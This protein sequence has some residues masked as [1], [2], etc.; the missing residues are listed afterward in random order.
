MVEVYNDPGDSWGF[1]EGNQGPNGL[2]ET[3]LPHPCTFPKG[4]GCPAGPWREDQLFPKES[5]HS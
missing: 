2:Q 3:A 5:G 1:G 4:P